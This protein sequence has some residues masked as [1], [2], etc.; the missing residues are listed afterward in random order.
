MH[1]SA[2]LQAFRFGD[3]SERTPD[4]D[5]DDWS[6]WCARGQH[7]EIRDWARLD[8]ARLGGDMGQLT[9]YSSLFEISLLLLFLCSPGA[10]DKHVP[11]A[12]YRR[13]AAG[14]RHVQCRVRVSLNPWLNDPGLLVCAA[15]LACWRCRYSFI[16][17]DIPMITDYIKLWWAM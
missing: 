5:S 17:R 13:L 14:C 1:G 4:L 15:F 2:V 11:S 9:R 6:F 8:W 7:R 3:F 16:I 10:P 12:E